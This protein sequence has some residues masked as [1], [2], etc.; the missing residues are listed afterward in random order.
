MP[1]IAKAALYAPDGSLV[2]TGEHRQILSAIQG[3]SVGMNQALHYLLGGDARL[4]GAG[5]F[6]PADVV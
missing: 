1:D 4:E 5:S 6:R 2:A 3:S